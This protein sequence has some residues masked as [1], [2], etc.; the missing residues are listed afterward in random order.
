[1]LAPQIIQLILLGFES[2]ITAAPQIGALIQKG[3][4]YFKSLADQGLITKEVQNALNNRLDQA[5]EAAI[6]GEVPIAWTVEP[7]PGT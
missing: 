2:A 6:A 1:M 7:D 3:K 4:D 5:G